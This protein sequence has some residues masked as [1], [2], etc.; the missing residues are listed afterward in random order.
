MLNLIDPSA[1]GLSKVRLLGTPQEHM[2]YEAEGVGLIM[3]LHLLNGLSRQLTHPTVIGTDSQAVIK[4]L[5]NQ[6]SHSG[7]Y[8]LDVIHHA[9]KRLHV[10]QDSLINNV[11]R[12]QTL[13]EGGKT[14][15]IV[16]L[17]LHW[18]PSH[19]NFEP[20]ERADEEAAAQHLCPLSRE[21]QKAETMLAT[22]LEK[23]REREPAKIH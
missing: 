10:K 11:E 8:L 2:V 20:N 5:Q 14:K 7:H 23:L 6:C 1:F 3:G 19:C 4:A 9:A 17:Q 12:Q 18:V 22:L 21:Q 15:G 13:A 16:D